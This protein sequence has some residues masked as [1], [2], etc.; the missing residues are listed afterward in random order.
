MKLNRKVKA[1]ISVILALIMLMS[2]VSVG[3]LTAS[4]ASSA[5]ITY[6]YLYN[7]AGY[8]EGRVTLSGNTS[9]YGTYWFYWA[10]STKALEGYAPITKLTLNRE[11]K[12]F[13]FEEFTVIPAG[14][15]KMIA[16]KSTTEPTN[17]T[18][19]SA[20]AVYSIPAS[21]QFKYKESA[22]EYDFAA[23]S[24]VHI[25]KQNPPYYTYSELHLSQT[26]E[27][28]TDRDLEFIT[29]CGDIIN[30]YDGLYDAEYTAYQKV[31]ADSSY[32][33]PIY[34][35][36]G[37]HETKSDGSKP[38]TQPYTTGFNKFKVATGLNVT[39]EKMQTNP[40][41]EITAPNGDHFIFMVLELDSSPNESGEFTKAQLD[42]VEGLLN[43]YKNDGHNI[44]IYEHAL[45]ESYG[46]G[47]DKVL[48]LYAGGLQQSYPEVQ[49]LIGMLEANP[50]VHFLSGH[51][52]LDFKYGYNIDN[53]GGD[54]CYTIHIP[55]LSCP[56]QI[57]GGAMD[58]TMY[59]D[60]SQGYFV[61]VYEDAVIYNGTD[62]CTNEYL[63]LYCY[64]I[65]Q[66]GQTL[67]KNNI[68]EDEIYGTMA[69]VNVD[70]SNLSANPEYVYCYAYN[71]DGTAVKYPG[72]LMK[73]Q[74]DGTYSCEVSA[75]YTNMYFFFQDPVLG[76]IGSDV[77]EV[78]NC[79]I[80][81]GYDLITYNNPSNWSVVN[82]YVWTES[83]TPFSWPGLAMS[84][85]SDGKW[86][87]RIPGGGAFDMIIFNNKPGSDQTADLD[88]TPYV[89]VGEAGSYTVVD[90]I[91]RPTIPTE[92]T[93]TPIITQP[94]TAEKTEPTTEKTEPTTEKTEPTTE[95]TE[96]TTEKAEPSTAP[97]T[98]DPESYLYGDADLNGQVNIKD[99]TLVQKYASKQA[100]LTDKAL[101][102]ANVTGDEAVNVRDATSIQKKAANMI[103]SFPVEA[104]SEIAPVGAT[105]TELTT[106]INSVKS[107]L[108]AEYKYASYDAYQALKK[109]YY[110]YKDKS[111]SSMSATQITAAHTAINKALTDYNTMKTNNG[112]SAT[113]P[114]T[115]SGGNITVYFTN[116][117]NWTTVN[118]YIWKNGGGNMKTWPGTSMTFVKTNSQNQD[119][120]SITYNS[121]LYDMI[122]FNNGSSS[123]TVDIA[124]TGV[125]NT[126]YY[127]SGGSGKALTCTSYIFGQ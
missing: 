60:K 2:T 16:I 53:R 13:S 29:I 45:I 12:S 39:T 68:G 14:A 88:I 69:S 81:I 27:A 95:K 21:K 26:L 11:S 123:Q 28:A 10:D 82:A 127:I 97:I 56:T 86:S 40:Y 18:V 102:Q 98:T 49:R 22:K 100:T 105:A 50:D 115:P 35:I 20:T 54:T 116:N 15:T 112:G 83:N 85:G 57:V 77:Y 94:T 79:K 75:D 41:Y 59:E 51:T 73:I 19:A 65:D 43:K 61:D 80:V 106:L 124:L 1:F 37:N 110:A 4:A 24:D 63:P 17:P 32:C 103:Q 33:N 46:A 119:V 93:T 23:L 114:S 8:A 36:T 6:S 118:A 44:F 108:S 117:Q 48:P 90:P 55:S 30:G 125:N 78:N 47:D 96:P 71:D 58:Y 126:G 121:S 62:L 111:V 31:L 92:A 84:K 9:D 42:W 3:I 72:I 87:V 101:M 109:Q 64:M 122:I 66:S 76:R 99:A 34:E 7:N 91:D 104:K 38:A 113:T 74:S 70:V 52:H 5:K 89:T 25:H 107:T 120:Y 67:S